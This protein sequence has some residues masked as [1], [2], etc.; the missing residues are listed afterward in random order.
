MKVDIL[1]ILPGLLHSYLQEG[2]VSRAIRAGTLTVNAI[3]IR[4][5]ADDKH[6]TTDDYP[7]GG[8][9]G[10][11]MKAE[12]LAHAVSSV[13]TK[14]SHVIYMSPMG[15]TFSHAKAQELAKKKH[16][17]FV[18]GRYEGV[19]QRFLDNYVDEEL[20]IGDYVLSGG[21]LAALVITDALAR[22]IPG[23]LGNENSSESDSFATGLLEH[24]QYTK[25][26]DFEGQSVP[27]VLLT[28]NHKLIQAWQ[29]KQACERTRDRRP[30][31]WSSYVTQHG[32]P[33]APPL[34]RR[35]KKQKKS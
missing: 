6:H 11:I 27:D 4:H 18:C 26:R 19:D 22:L 10:L 14:D 16:L 25:P 20:S 23:V 32:D 31:L 15:Q 28:G 5:F 21:E 3:N 29:F 2:V 1:T 9:P 12:P 30:D 33:L 34:S 17:V 13:K 24:P 8:G 35:A 7:Y